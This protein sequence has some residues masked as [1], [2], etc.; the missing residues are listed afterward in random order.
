VKI[1]IEMWLQVTLPQLDQPYITKICNASE[2]IAC[3]LKLAKHH[4]LYGGGTGRKKSKGEGA[5][6]TY[7]IINFILKFSAKG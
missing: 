1:K 4:R 5:R 7:G 2:R 3:T 6:K